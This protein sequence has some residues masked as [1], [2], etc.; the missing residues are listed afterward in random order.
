MQL[1]I[2]EAVNHTLEQEMKNDKSIVLLGEDIGVDGGVFRATKGLIKKFPSRV[3]DTPLAESAIIGCS[4]GMAL[5]G[6]KP[7]PEIQFSGFMYYAFHQLESHVARIRNRTRGSFTLPMVIRTPYG[8]G[9]RALEHHSESLEAIYV[10]CKGIKI[11]IPS[12]PYDTKG[13]LAAAIKDPDPVI[14]FEPKKIYRAFK[15]EVPEKPYTIPIGKANVVKEGTDATLIAYGAM[16]RPTMRAAEKVQHEVDCEIIDLRT[17][18]PY[19]M[20]TVLKSVKKTGR[21]VIIHEAPRSCGFGAEV[22]AQINEKLALELKAPVE[23]VTGFDVPMPL[24]K[25]EDYYLPDENRII[26]AIEKVINF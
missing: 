9:I 19:D 15:Q 1:N 22:S 6:L 18:M 7:I 23:R 10:Q 2:V 20:E 12:T 17:I 24:L 21:A 4:I 3:F 14:F 25:L 13:L 16:M 11:V 5:N 8:G 26:S